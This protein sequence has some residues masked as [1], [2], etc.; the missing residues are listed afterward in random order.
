M[1]R[2]DEKATPCTCEGCQS[3]DLASNPFV[4]LR[5]AYGMLLGEEDFQVLLGYPR[6]KQMVHS[7]WLHGSGVVWG[8]GVRCADDKNL[9]IDPGLALDGIGRELVNRTCC[10]LDL[11]QL[12]EQYVASGPPAATDQSSGG[13]STDSCTSWSVHVCLVASFATCLTSAV[14]TLSDPCDV[15]RSHD[16]YSR[17]V[18]QVGFTLVE[19]CCPRP[20]QDY[21]RVRVLLGLEEVGTDDEAGEEALAARAEV[22]G[23]PTSERAG[24]LLRQFRRLAAWDTTDLR[25]DTHEGDCDIAPFPVDDEDAGVPIACLSFRVVE[26]DGCRLI[27]DVCVDE[28]VRTSLLPTRTVQELACGLA[29]ALIG[30]T[31]G[32]VV[33]GPQVIGPEVVLEGSGRRLVIPVTAPLTSSSVHGAVSITSLST[34]RGGGWV[35]EDIYDTKFLASRS[36]IVVTLADRPVN[37]LIRIVIRGT[38]PRP[39]MGKDPVVPLAGVV[40]DHPFSRYDGL[41]AVWTFTHESPPEPPTDADES[42]DED[43]HEEEGA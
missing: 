21:H 12:A 15:T 30:D 6:G 7:S 14:P 9:A 2:C 10:C 13:G 18:E 37:P 24:E 42:E 35:V 11:Y 41:D 19:G 23:A 17:V 43:E 20:R 40:G 32:A 3:G 33:G 25:P 27:E 36:A 34:K 1:T 31:D 16:D 28:T 22:L 26:R 8:Y 5:V 38:G 29:P 39:V 4:A